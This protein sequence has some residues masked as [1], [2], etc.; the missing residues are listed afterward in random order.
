MGENGL[1]DGKGVRLW[2]TKWRVNFV[3]EAPSPTQPLSS[4]KGTHFGPEALGPPQH[5]LHLSADD[6]CSA[7]S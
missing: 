2:G 5:S 6:T 7:R 3:Q 4:P 1:G